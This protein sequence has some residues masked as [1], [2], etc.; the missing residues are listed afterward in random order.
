MPALPV[1]PGVTKV[2]ISGTYH[3]TIWENIWFTHYS[4]SPPGVTDVANYGAYLTS[5]TMPQYQDEMSVDNE[6]T[7]WKVVDLSSDTGAVAEGSVSQF[8]SRTGDFNPANVALV[9]SLVIGRR[10]RGGHP[11]K[12][13]PWGTSGTF[14]SGST[15][16]WDSGF[17]ADCTTKLE[18]I[19]GFL[20][21]HVEG[22]TTWDNVV[23]V[24]Y[25]T[26][27]ARRVTPVVDVV[28]SI[29]PKVR[30]CS[31]RRRLGKVGG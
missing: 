29:V 1:V 13:L 3:D 11:R 17:I 19:R 8:G 21:G 12:Y 5:N 15:K 10:Y 18:S 2:T 30:V 26:A 4:G 9:A 31:Q 6:I 22:S 27:H 20:G 23:N 28:T 14:A 16:D 24:S 7:G 25:N